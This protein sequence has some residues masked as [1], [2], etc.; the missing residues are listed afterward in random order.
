MSIDAIAVT[1]GNGRIGEAILRELN[2]HGYRTVNLARGSRRESVSDEY[3]TVDLLDAGEVYGG[4]ARSDADAIVHMGTIPSPTNHPGYVTYRSNVMSTYH[5]LEAATELGLEAACLASSINAMGGAF[6]EA[7]A[8]VFYLPVDEDHP[9]TPRDPYAISK[10]VI[11]TTAD[12]FGRLEDA[13]ATISSL[14]YPWVARGDELRERFAD[15]DRSLAGVAGSSHATRHDLFSYLHVDDAARVA[16]LAVEADYTG[17][18][19]FWA[20]ADDTTAA[21]D[22]DVLAAEFYPDA[23]RRR[24]LSGTEALVDTGKAE[25]L[26]GWTPE[27]TWREL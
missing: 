20:V 10:H 6:Q 9:L 1:G 21:V 5:V 14:R 13:P 27:R 26:L 17:H 4:L 7:P 11:E 18:E 8:E 16:R 19:V 22:S 25:R 24:A 2:D 12:G 3:R 15:A 23:E